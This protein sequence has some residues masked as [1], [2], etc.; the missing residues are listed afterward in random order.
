MATEFTLEISA[1][2][3]I[4]DNDERG[5]L[6]INFE[7]GSSYGP[8]VINEEKCKCDCPDKLKN[9][10][11][12][13]NLKD[14]P[15]PKDQQDVFAWDCETSYEAKNEGE[16]QA[17]DNAVRPGLNNST[18]TY[19]QRP[20]WVQGCK[21]C[22]C[23]I[24]APL[25]IDWSYDDG[26]PC[27]DGHSCNAAVFNFGFLRGQINQG[28]LS[29]GNGATIAL[30]TFNLNNGSSG[31]PVKSPT[32]TV[33]KEQIENAL[34]EDEYGNTKLTMYVRCALDYCHQGIS[35]CVMKDSSGATLI[36]T[37]FDSGETTVT[38]CEAPDPEA[39]G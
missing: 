30:G 36:D 7:A 37:C 31:G 20:A 19:P 12:P 15:N 39:N 24:N 11:K 21:K 34:F 4:K 26:P 9:P 38:L 28:Q 10:P 5:K 17:H 16:A 13:Y 2:G 3:P 23:P 29:G 14:C 6:I 8:A 22:K 18:T 1:C 32:V 33:S 25:T 27:G 35:H